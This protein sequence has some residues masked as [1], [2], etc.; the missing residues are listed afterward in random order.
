[1]T[2]FPP[3]SGGVFGATHWWTSFALLGHFSEGGRGGATDD[4]GGGGVTDAT[5]SALFVGALGALVA[6]GDGEGA[7]A[8]STV[9]ECDS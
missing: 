2:T 8:T 3:V 5:A 7:G 9:V 4:A 6:L 1:V